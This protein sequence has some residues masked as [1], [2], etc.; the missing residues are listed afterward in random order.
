LKTPDT[1]F[2][3][4][5]PKGFQVIA[6]SIN[7]EK[8]NLQNANKKLIEYITA[9]KVA[10][11]INSQDKDRYLDY[12]VD[13]IDNTKY[14]NYSSFCVYFQVCKFSYAT[15]KSIK[16]K[17][18][19]K[20]IIDKMLNNYIENR[21]NTYCSYGYSD[22]VLQV[23]SDSSSSR[24]NSKTG[25]NKIEENIIPFGFKKVKTKDDYLLENKCY[26]LPDKGDAN[27]FHKI[28]NFNKIDFQFK[29]NR[30]NK[31]PDVLLKFNKNIFIV[32]HKLTNGSG[33]AQNFEIN[34]II[35][36]IGEKENNKNVSYISC[37]Q[38][39]YINLLTLDSPKTRIQ[40]NNITKN[41]T[42][43]KLNFFVNGN[44][45]SLLIKDI[46]N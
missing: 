4:S 7:D 43:N 36:F 6:K 37:L 24:R 31:N 38:G 9:Y 1:T 27:L 32:E 23:M 40:L 2:D 5:N 17:N 29:N 20:Y 41:L 19:K 11:E 33:G 16:N 28:I 14:I 30:D 10:K 8:T 3:F 42:K 22:Q 45:F 21:H 26:I 12:I 25:I 44:G 13:L 35:S 34:E 46:C 39:D 18:D 15:F